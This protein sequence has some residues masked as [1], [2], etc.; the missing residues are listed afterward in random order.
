MERNWSKM[1]QNRMERELRLGPRFCTKDIPC[2]QKQGSGLNIC[3]KPFY[4]GR[5]GLSNFLTPTQPPLIARLSP[6]AGPFAGSFEGTRAGS[7]SMA[8]G[9]KYQQMTQVL[10]KAELLNL[11]STKS[12]R[13]LLFIKVYYNP[14]IYL[15]F[16]SLYILII[17]IL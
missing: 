5:D 1:A 16:I 8:K 14:D 9:P 7:S 12:N 10:P 2:L 17:K 4:D 13:L 3:E 6:R 15:L 11:K